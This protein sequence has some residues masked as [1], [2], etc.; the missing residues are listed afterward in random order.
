M[1]RVI[2]FD[3]D[4]TLWAVKPIIIRAEQ[5]L[6]GFLQEAAP[7]HAIDV[8]VMRA[9]RDRIVANDP[10]LAHRLT[11]LRRRVIEAALAAQGADEEIARR[12]SFEA[13][14]VFLAARND[15][16][17][18]DG[19]IEGLATLSRDYVLGALSNGN[20]DIR[21]LGLDRY[22]SFAFSAEE[23]GAPKPEPHLFE[24]AMKHIGITPAQMVYVGDDPVL[25]VDAA[26]RLGLTTVWMVNPGKAG[27][28][29]TEPDATITNLREL[30]DV[31]AGLRARG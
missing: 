4:D 13:I 11:E 21:R 27:T 25:D 6:A 9:L 28:G 31:I 8:E 14:E 15:I 12:I 16:E 5:K 29:E 19:V 20:A 18:F 17:F 26:N 24:A 2:G 22:F 10:T 1:I 23:V 7:E 3:L 30:P